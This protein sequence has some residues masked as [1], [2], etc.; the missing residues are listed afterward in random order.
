METKNSASFFANREC[1]YYP[2]HEC[3]TDINCLFCYCPLYNTD[4]PGN[5]TMIESDG[6]SVK[7]CV[8]CTFPH[9]PSNYG[10]VIKLLKQ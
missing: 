5:Y 2:C 9:I 3:D 10:K 4:C 1:R 6:R 8:D 7:S